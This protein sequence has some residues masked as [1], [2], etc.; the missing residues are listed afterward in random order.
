MRNADEQTVRGFG[1]EWERFDQASLT[2]RERE[3]HNRVFDAYFAVFPW[4]T[5]SP[6]AEGFDLGCGSGRWA[7]ICATRVG[8]LHCIDP[9]S[10]IDVARRNLTDLPN[11]SFHKAGVDAIPLADGSMDFGYSLGV[12]HHIPDTGAALASCTAKL[13]PG[14]PF[15]VYL[16]YAMQNRPIWYRGIW[17]ASEILRYIVSKLPHRLRFAASQV[18]ALF[19]YLPL[20]KSAV[21]AEWLGMDVS[22][23][24]LSDYRHRSFYMIRNNALDRFGTRLEQRFTREQIHDMMVAADLENIVFSEKLPFWCAVGT[25]KEPI[26]PDSTE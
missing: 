5:L 25:K 8:K 15:L 7:K 18:L 3:E 16:Y 26:A 9:S 19:V 24:P 17:K 6:D 20:T 12:L 22:N 13:K 1:D 10:A 2:P 4:H 21:L 11:L 14:A 23:F